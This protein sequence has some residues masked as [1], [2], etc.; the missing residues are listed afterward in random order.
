LLKYAAYLIGYKGYTLDE[1]PSKY[2]LWESSSY[3]W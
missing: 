1:R 3:L 2:Q